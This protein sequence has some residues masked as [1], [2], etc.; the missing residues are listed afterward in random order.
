M[1]KKLSEEEIL[2][3][4]AQR[5][6]GDKYSNSNIGNIRKTYEINKAN[7]IISQGSQEL[8]TQYSVLETL[9]ALQKAVNE[10]FYDS[11]ETEA[12]LS[13]IL[14]NNPELAQVVSEAYDIANLA[15]SNIILESSDD[16]QRVIDS[17]VANIDTTASTMANASSKKTKYGS[18]DAQQTAQEY[19][20]IAKGDKQVTSV[21]RA[22]GETESTLK[23][24]LDDYMKNAMIYRQDSINRYEITGEI[25]EVFEQYRTLLTT[26]DAEGKEVVPSDTAVIRYMKEAQSQAKKT[27]LN[28]DIDTDGSI[29]AN[30]AIYEE[31]A[32]LKI[33]DQ[34]IALQTYSNELDISNII[35][36]QAIDNLYKGVGGTGDVDITEKIKEIS[37]HFAGD[38]QTEIQ[39]E[40]EKISSQFVTEL[41]VAK[42]KNNTLYAEGSN[43][44]TEWIEA[45]K[46]A[47]EKLTTDVQN[48]AW[49]LLSMG[50]TDIEVSAIL[51]SAYGVSEEQASSFI[52]SVR[53]LSYDN[54]SG[55][56]KVDTSAFNMAFNGE[57]VS[58][59]VNNMIDDFC[60]GLDSASKAVYSQKYGAM[61]MNIVRQESLKEQGANYSNALANFEAEM[62]KT[63]A[64]TMK[65]MFSVTSVSDYSTSDSTKDAKS[66][67]VKYSK[68]EWG[69][70][71]NEGQLYFTSYTSMIA[72]AQA[73]QYESNIKMLEILGNDTSMSTEIRTKTCTA[74]AINTLYGSEVIKAEDLK[75]MSAKDMWEQAVNLAGNSLQLNTIAV[76]GDIYYT[77]SLGLQGL[78]KYSTDAWWI[79]S[80][81]TDTSVLYTDAGYVYKCQTINGETVY[82]KP[83]FNG[84]NVSTFTFYSDK[85][86]IQPLYNPLGEAL[87][88]LSNETLEEQNIQTQLQ[89][90][91]SFSENNSQENLLFADIELREGDSLEEIERKTALG[92][93]TVAYKDY[94]GQTRYAPL[95]NVQ[96]LNNFTGGVELIGLSATNKVS[97]TTKRALEL[98]QQIVSMQ[99]A[100]KNAPTGLTSLKISDGSLEVKHS[101][102][103]GVNNISTVDGQ[104]YVIDYE[105]GTKYSL[106]SDGEITP[107]LTNK[108]SDAKQKEYYLMA[109]EIVTRSNGQ[110]AIADAYEAISMAMEGYDECVTVLGSNNKVYTYIPKIQ[111]YIVAGW[112]L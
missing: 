88:G 6:V 57:D 112:Y 81:F 107:D 16:I 9:N 108:I 75:T 19:K 86:C 41:T 49:A 66:K 101:K 5:I 58:G 48:S 69:N 24:A 60:S 102:S 55:I 10:G 52:Q 34:V 40:K 99:K 100:Y 38:T 94:T 73:S 29:I 77:G 46:K 83:T 36:R 15:D 104:L 26:K 62:K 54:T 82:A 51:Q 27:Y 8:I 95:R 76:L 61:L 50:K 96:E 92:N 68:C 31:Q 56:F 74:L 45:N 32:T 79:D 103:Y 98:N 106:G 97:F 3:E 21:S 43:L 18:T 63:T 91:N 12:V 71:Y 4:S 59:L 23:T 35:D 11:A 17:I 7:S 44:A 78:S 93:T 65:E 1:E 22:Y 2:N 14:A 87:K 30:L 28:V 67:G 90:Y 53:T 20:N 64:K 25:D 89:Q 39:K 80:N 47:K 33:R 37:E 110:V 84:E 70:K 85:N 109:Q 13:D 72:D 105:N 111:Q 42:K